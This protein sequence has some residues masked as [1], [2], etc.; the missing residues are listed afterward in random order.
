MTRKYCL[1]IGLVCWMTVVWVMLWG[2]VSAANI[3]A[4]FA[5][6]LLITVLLPL[7]VVPV[8]GRLHPLS[9]LRL[10][11]RVVI[12]L[13][14][15]STQLAWLTV[16]SGPPPQSALVRAPL[17][18]KSDLTLALIAAILT[19]IPGTMVVDIDQ[20]RRILYVHILDVRADGAIADFYKQLAHLEKLVI[21]AFEREH[22]WRPAAQEAQ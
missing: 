7:P 3:L 18:V 22:E 13:I 5:V 9:L 11:G 19:L 2:T 20:A 4:G 15:A 10:L 16:R 14:K 17:S 6:A 12:D 1:R 21:A 8:Q